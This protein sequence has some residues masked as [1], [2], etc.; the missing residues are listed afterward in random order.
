MIK[1]SNMYGFQSQSLIDALI[2]NDYDLKEKPINVFS[3]TEV[4]DAPKPKVLWRRHENEITMDVS[5]MFYTLMGSAKHYVFEQSNKRNGR[6]AE[7]RLYIC[8]NTGHVYTLPDPKNKETILEQLKN[9]EWYNVKYCYVSCKIDVYDHE[10][11]CLEDYKSTSVFKARRD[12]SPDW[13]AQVNCGGLAIRRIGFDVDKVRVIVLID[14]WSAAKLKQDEQSAAKAGVNCNYPVVKGKEYNNIRL[15]SDEECLS[16]LAER[17]KLH[18]Q[19]YSLSDDAIPP[20]NQDERWYRGESYAIMKAGNVKATKVLKLEDFEDK[21]QALQVVEATLNQ[22]KTDKP[23]EADKYSIEVR[24]G[25]D[26]RCNGDVRYCHVCHWC[27][28]WRDTYQGKV[29]IETEGY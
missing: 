15:W 6:L 27:N 26:G 4:I 29:T 16:Y 10:Q 3:L 28:Y 12:C 25:N 21:E 20:C 13:E 22:Y 18:V 2:H 9:T 19:A 17:V 1:F 5:D 24:P 14:G 8:I 23:K 7:E 11:K